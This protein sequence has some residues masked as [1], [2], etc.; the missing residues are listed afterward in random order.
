MCDNLKSY[1][2]A[3]V[4]SCAASACEGS[5][6]FI[7]TVR[8]EQCLKADSHHAEAKQA[9]I[10]SV[11]EYENDWKAPGMLCVVQ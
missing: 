6:A 5:P 3:F 1:N 7:S 8:L 11:H 4:R 10:C 9:L 2:D